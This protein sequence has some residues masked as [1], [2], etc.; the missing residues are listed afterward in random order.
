MSRVCKDDGQILLLE[1]GA[2][3][4]GWLS[5]YLDSK[6]PEH[7]ERWGCWWNRD[8]LRIVRD[9]GLVV[10]DAKRKTFGTFYAIRAS[11]KRPSKPTAS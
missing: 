10:V 6:A 2:S 9:S 11:P 7:S 3:T 8:I 4:Y 5:R 1:H